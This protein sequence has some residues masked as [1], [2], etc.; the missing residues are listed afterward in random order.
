MSIEAMW[1]VLFGSVILVETR[2]E[3]GNEDRPQIQR[4]R[5]QVP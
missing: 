1:N 2:G 4:P 5:M 3:K